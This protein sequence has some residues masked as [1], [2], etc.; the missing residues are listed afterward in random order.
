MIFRQYY[1]ATATLELVPAWLRF[2]ESRRLIDAEQREQ[3]LANLRG[4]DT[5]F[6]KVVKDHSDPGL[7][8]AMEQ[9]RSNP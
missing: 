1:K 4:L 7:R 5:E 8:L 2:L 9:W 6:L 3:T